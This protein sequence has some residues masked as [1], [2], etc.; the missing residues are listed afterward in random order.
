ML[1]LIGGEIG[2]KLK[3]VAELVQTLLSQAVETRA[4]AKFMK[5]TKMVRKRTPRK[6]KVIV[7]GRMT[8]QFF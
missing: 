6:I 8:D 1:R 5:K 4:I 3:S 2:K 7:W